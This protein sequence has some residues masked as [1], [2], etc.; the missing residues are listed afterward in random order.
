MTMYYA[1]L[2]NGVLSSEVTLPSSNEIYI[3]WPFTFGSGNWSDFK[4]SDMGWVRGGSNTT[5]LSN[6]ITVVSMAVENGVNTVP[7]TKAASR[8]WVITAG[9]NDSQTDSVT[10][11]SLGLTNFARGTTV[12][13]KAKLSL[14]SVGL[15]LA[16]MDVRNTSAMA[17]TQIYW[18]NSANDTVVSS[19]DALGV[20]T[21][22]G[23]APLLP[24][25]SWCPIMI[26]TPIG[27]PDPIVYG[28][29]DS[30][31]AGVGDDTA[32]A[33]G[34]GF[35]MRALIDN[36]TSSRILAGANFCRSS[37]T[38]TSFNAATSDRLAYW[39]KYATYAVDE[40]GTNDFTAT[41]AFISS[42]TFLTLCRTIWTKLKGYGV[43][44]I[45]RTK[46]LPRTSSTDGWKY[47][48][49]QTVTGAGWDTGGEAILFNAAVDGEV[50]TNINA[51]ANMNGTRGQNNPLLWVQDTYTGV[52]ITGYSTT[53]GLHPAKPMHIVMASSLRASIDS[54]N[55]SIT[56]LSTS[57]TYGQSGT[58]VTAAL[59]TLTTM[60]IDGVAVASVNA[61]AG[62]GSFVMAQRVNGAP[63]PSYGSAKAVFV[64][65]GSS[66]ATGVIDVVVA[67][68]EAYQ[69]I[70]SPVATDGNYLHYYMTLT[71]GD[72]VSFNTAAT[73][74][75]TN[76]QINANSQ[77]VTD[78]V[79]SQTIWIRRASTGIVTQ[80]TVTK[81]IGGVISVV[82][83][84]VSTATVGAVQK[85]LKYMS[86]GS[87]ITYLS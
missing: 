73:Q 40:Y 83:G 21:Y 36:G 1:S 62:S 35:F 9:L 8:T 44:K 10:A 33:L 76:N 55:T 66:T 32:N 41:G 5:N 27:T 24:T 61:P 80:A 54:L 3:R 67:T 72:Q 16:Q 15:K 37:T 53:D 50:G 81:T 26:G 2:Q 70:A 59:G 19:V 63:I 11:A 87:L 65:D 74:G 79:G 30:I 22:T 82:L 4:F 34:Y 43:S 71:N 86:S 39:S 56:S 42:A 57:L 49:N 23:T 60:T 85:Q 14:A 7:I 84:G 45:I 64:G 75:V 47:E 17:G 25:S 77:I 46:L 12:W 52:P 69:T 78:F 29:G 48:I 20:F 51:I 13:L 58:I 38:A 28:Y 31:G 68:G 6:S 18:T